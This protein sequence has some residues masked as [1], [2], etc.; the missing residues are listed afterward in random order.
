[1]AHTSGKSS[2]PS[3]PGH[4]GTGNQ[5]KQRT[6]TENRRMDFAGLNILRSPLTPKTK[7]P[8]NGA[9]IASIKNRKP[10]KEGPSGTSYG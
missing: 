3:S 9:M 10:R 2:Y 1:M 4:P 5:A 6:G 7:I 8:E